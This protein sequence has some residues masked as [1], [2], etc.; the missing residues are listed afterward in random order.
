MMKNGNKKKLDGNS[1]L[2]AVTIVLFFAMYIVPAIIIVLVT[3]C[4]FVL[5]QGFLVA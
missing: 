5:V 4:V 2:F 1:F 3:G